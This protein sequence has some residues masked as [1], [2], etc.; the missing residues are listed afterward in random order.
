MFCTIARPNV[1]VLYIENMWINFSKYSVDLQNRAFISVNNLMLVHN[2]VNQVHILL[3][4]R[5]CG[6]QCSSMLFWKW[7]VSSSYII[8]VV[9]QRVQIVHC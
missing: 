6:M 3:T 9:N 8:V 7:Q 4:L 1:L 5:L 2:L